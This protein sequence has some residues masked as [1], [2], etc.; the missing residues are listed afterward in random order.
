MSAMTV[1]SVCVTPAGSSSAPTP[2]DGRY[3]EN[4]D[5]VHEIFVEHAEHDVVTMT[6]R[7]EGSG[8]ARSASE[9]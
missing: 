7:G 5:R 9:R 2:A 3:R 6:M 1:S 8:S 4:R